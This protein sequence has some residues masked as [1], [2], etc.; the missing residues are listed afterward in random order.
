MLGQAINNH[1]SITRSSP[2]VLQESTH[3]EQFSH[4]VHYIYRWLLMKTWYCY[5]LHFNVFREICHINH[6]RYRHNITEAFASS[7]K[8]LHWGEEVFN[9]IVKNSRYMI[10]IYLARISDIIC[11]SAI[12]IS[13]DLT[14]LLS[15]WDDLFK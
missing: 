14:C 1:C 4:F 15:T 8:I 3:L 10:I 2:S 13:L 9:N 6:T 5:W 7:S 12:Y 11:R